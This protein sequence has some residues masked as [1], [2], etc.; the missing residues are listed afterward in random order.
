MD[1]SVWVGV[2]LGG[3]CYSRCGILYAPVLGGGE[4]FLFVIFI[5]QSF[6]N[7]NASLLYLS[8]YFLIYFCNPLP[9]N[10]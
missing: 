5:S 6:F 9:D 2:G 3:N 8:A 10:G 7:K 4:L 1:L